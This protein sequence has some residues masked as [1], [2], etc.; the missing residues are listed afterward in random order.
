MMLRRDISESRS[1]DG[2]ADGQMSVRLGS[3]ARQRISAEWPGMW[4]TAAG[5][6]H[7]RDYQFSQVHYHLL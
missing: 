3:I 1:A 2:G 4:Q 5:A 7:D 6:D